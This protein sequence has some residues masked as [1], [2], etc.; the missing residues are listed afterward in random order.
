LDK[1]ASELG[2]RGIYIGEWHSHLVAEPEPSPDDIKSL[3]G[4]SK[5]P[6]YLTRCPVMVISGFDPNIS[7]VTSLRSWVFPVGGRIYDIPNQ[8]VSSDVVATF[9]ERPVIS[10]KPSK[11]AGSNT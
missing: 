10:Q 9:L 6:N 1:A 11:N 8:T 5:A 2:P 4:I 7:K 3:F